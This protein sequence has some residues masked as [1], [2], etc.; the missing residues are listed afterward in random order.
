[1]NKPNDNP[2]PGGQRGRPEASAGR[3][4][5]AALLAAARQAFAEHGFRAASLRAI[6]Q[7]ADVNPAMVH[8]YFGNKK[9]LYRAML[10]EV[11]EPT[12]ERLA[13]LSDAGEDECAFPERVL[14]LYAET[15]RREPWLPA[16]VVRDVLA[17]DGP[18]RR[19]FIDLVGQRVGGT[20]LPD[21]I[22]KEKAAGHLRQDLDTRLTT[23]SLLSLAVF[24]MLAM[25]V[26][27]PLLGY[28]M[29][30]ESLERL[31]THNAKLFENGTHAD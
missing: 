22:E 5:R 27:G 10:A 4:V 11:L 26:A 18:A 9:G 3:D 2:E 31:I 28:G 16:L 30:A 6:A 12:V 20:L 7:A 23:L 1:M 17:A 21:L 19:V 13:T 29:D 25:P 8:Y 14:R 15:M 24:P